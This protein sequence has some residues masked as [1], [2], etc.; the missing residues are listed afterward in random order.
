MW[1]NEKKKY[2]EANK[3]K[4]LLVCVG[5]LSPE[6]GVDEL[7]KCLPLMKD[8]A[9]WL[10]GDGPYSP[11]LEHLTEELNVPKREALHTA[12]TV[13]VST[14]YSSKSSCI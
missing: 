1:Q 11:T 3:C 8:T 4:S 5:R 6:K 12:Y 13:A 14:R 2:L 7:I 10:V 9:L